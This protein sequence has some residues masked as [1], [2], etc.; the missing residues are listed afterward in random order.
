[1]QRATAF[2]SFTK[3][4]LSPAFNPGPCRPCHGEMSVDRLELAGP[5]RRE[6]WCSQP[7][8]H[9]GPSEGVHFGA[10]RRGMIPALQ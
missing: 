8:L 3:G 9:Q 5:E 7:G 1:M 2:P 6:F 4:D 10:P